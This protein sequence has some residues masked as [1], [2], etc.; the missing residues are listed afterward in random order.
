MKIRIS[1][2]IKVKTTQNWI[3]LDLG[4]VRTVFFKTKWSKKIYKSLW[5]KPRE[6]NQTNKW[7]MKIQKKYLKIPYK[8][9][10]K[11]TLRDVSQK[12]P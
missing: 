1:N 3:D 2:L 10:N 9:L 5:Y 11:N 6:I 12:I 4:T 7:T 8:T